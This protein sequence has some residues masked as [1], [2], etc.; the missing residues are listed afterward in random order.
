MKQRNH[1]AVAAEHVLGKS[2]QCLLRSN[3]NKHAS[4]SVVERVQSL[5]KL[6]RRGDLLR[7][8]V[9]HLRNDVGPRGIKL[10]VS[11]GDDWQAGR[12]EMQAL[13]NSP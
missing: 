9:Q 4:A 10:A 5:N 6:H 11:V 1:V 2:L 3:F 8:N 13:Q 7:E 12:F